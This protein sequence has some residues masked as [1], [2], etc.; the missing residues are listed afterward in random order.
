MTSGHDF[1]YHFR[2]WLPVPFLVM[3]SDTTSG[4]DFQCHFRSSKFKTETSGH[5]FRYHFR[6]WLLVPLL[7]MT[8]GTT[9]SYDFQCYFRSSKF[10]TETSWFPF[11]SLS[12]TIMLLLTLA[13]LGWIKT[14]GP[15]Y[16]CCS[17]PSV[18]FWPKTLFLA[19]I[20]FQNRNLLISVPQSF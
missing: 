19:K 11:V 14:L 17:E 5:D 4:Y 8:S 16:L 9:S 10:K 2:S 7:V 1:R 3:T 20:Q 12:N 15:W 13:S 18:W 6:S